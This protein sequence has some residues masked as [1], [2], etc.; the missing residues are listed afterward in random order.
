MLNSEDL[1]ILS[2]NSSKASSASVPDPSLR[3]LSQLFSSPKRRASLPDA[4]LSLPHQRRG[5]PRLRPSDPDVKIVHGANLSAETAGVREIICRD[6]LSDACA[7]LVI[8]DPERLEL[9]TA[10]P[11][12]VLQPI[13]D[14]SIFN[15]CTPPLSPVTPCLSPLFP[16]LMHLDSEEG[17]NERCEADTSDVLMDGSVT[18][19]D[20]IST[21]KSY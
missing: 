16:H 21:M 13:L 7:E 17:L 15:Y 10:P 8:P 18:L 3:R 4:R 12:P 2:E 19:G 5:V 6:D 20:V 11:S 9:C 14:P 1:E